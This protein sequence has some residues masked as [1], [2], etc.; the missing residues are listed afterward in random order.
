MSE[1][2]E[3]LKRR[4]EDYRDMYL[5]AVDHISSLTERLHVEEEINDK[6]RAWFTKNAHW[7]NDHNQRE[8][9]TIDDIQ[10]ESIIKNEEEVNN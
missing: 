1:D 9:S 6:Y 7:T 4:A 10:E 2:L 8:F 5:R 3:T